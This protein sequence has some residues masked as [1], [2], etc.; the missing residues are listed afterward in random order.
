MTIVRNSFECLMVWSMKILV[1]HAFA[2][3]SDI[4]SFLYFDLICFCFVV[5]VVVV[6]DDFWHSRRVKGKA[7]GQKSKVQVS[8]LNEDELQDMGN[9]VL[10]LDVDEIG[11][12]KLEVFKGAVVSLGDIQGFDKDQLVKLAEVAKEAYK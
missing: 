3:V 10:G 8:E 4:R 12:L 2:Q 11:Q 9:A 1:L 7:R 5:V 6:V